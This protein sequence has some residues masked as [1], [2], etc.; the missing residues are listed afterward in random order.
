MYLTQ[1]EFLRLADCE[2]KS[3]MCYAYHEACCVIIPR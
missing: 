1:D 2:M 3:R